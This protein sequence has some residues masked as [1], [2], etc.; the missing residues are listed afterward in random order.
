MLYKQAYQNIKLYKYY[1]K[2]RL[3][4]SCLKFDSYQWGSNPAKHRPYSRQ[5][6]NGIANKNGWKV[7]IPP[8]LD[9]R[10]N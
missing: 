1:I 9:I 5:P 3:G 7:V 6:G 8:Y 4:Q 2:Y 10:H